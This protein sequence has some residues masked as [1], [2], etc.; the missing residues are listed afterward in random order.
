MKTVLLVCHDNKTRN[1]IEKTLSYMGLSVS[2]AIEVAVAWRFLESIRFDFVM[3]DMQLGE[4]SGLNFYKSLRQQGNNIP[5]MMIGDGDFDKFML[6]DLAPENY[7]YLLKPIRS[8][9]LR[10]RLNH[11]LEMIAYKE[12]FHVFGNLKIDMR[13]QILIYGEK[14]LQLSSLELDILLMLAQKGGGAIHPK[15]ITK[16]LEKEG[17]FYAMS[18]FYYVN[19]LRKKLQKYGGNAIDI[20]FIK[21]QGYKLSF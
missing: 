3:V 14:L 11:F 19:V 13:Q 10:Q 5:V 1:V 9:A 4:E 2:V 7:D 17:R 18:S 8:G 20:C 15:K 21:D 12:K 6:Q 16:L